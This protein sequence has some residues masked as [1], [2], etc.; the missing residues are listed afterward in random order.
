MMNMKRIAMLAVLFSACAPE[1]QELGNVTTATAG[2]DADVGVSTEALGCVPE[3]QICTNSRAEAVI[4]MGGGT[5]QWSGD[6]APFAIWNG[7]G[8]VGRTVK[9]VQAVNSTSSSKR[10]YEPSQ[11]TPFYINCRCNGSQ[12][13]GCIAT[14]N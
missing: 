12:Y 7:R 5:W 6:C 10:R 11:Q 13:L 2:S 8:P 14:P 9:S 4:K 3:S 1:A